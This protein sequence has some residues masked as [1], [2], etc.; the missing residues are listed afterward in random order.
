VLNYRIASSSFLQLNTILSS[1]NITD[2][3]PVNPNVRKVFLFEN[4]FG[5]R[6]LTS[7][8]FFYLGLSTFQIS[9]DNLDI[10][11][12]SKALQ[13]GITTDFSYF[14]SNNDRLD[15]QLN[16]IKYQYDTPDKDDNNDR[17]EIRFEGIARYFHR[18]SQLLWLDLN[19]YVYLNHMMY[20]YKE[21]SAN[22]NWNRKYRI[23]SVVNYKHNN[24]RNTLRTQVLANYIAYD[25][26][27][28]FTNTRSFIN[29]QYSVSDSL[30]VPLFYRSFAGFYIRLELKDRGAFFKES[31]AQNILESTQILYY[32]LFFKKEN[33]L[34]L[35][36]EIGFAYYQE[37][38]WR[39]IS[40][41]V[42]SRVSPY[43]RIIYPMGRNLRFLS[44]IV[45]NYLVERGGEESE[46]TYGKLD[47]YYHF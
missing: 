46:Y 11:T 35:N 26:D 1:E 47:L 13:T 7:S 43:L 34:R 38:N 17:D 4:R 2:N 8:L 19:V 31:F 29:R 22:N 32:D 3:T 14:F 10:K 39:L 42:I 15:L 45:Q 33:I 37:K 16:F 28:L 36:F 23:Q 5:Y 20:L 41:G 44:Q 9:H 24:W 12:D 6:Y 27:H 25:F 40:V 18:F 30:L 21:Q